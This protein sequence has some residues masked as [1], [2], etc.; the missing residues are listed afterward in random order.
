MP[1]ER[2]PDADGPC[3]VMAAVDEGSLVIADVNR[4]GAWVS[5]SPG[6]AAPLSEW[7]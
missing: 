1:R 7:R 6:H 2:P 4:D 5:T 3:D